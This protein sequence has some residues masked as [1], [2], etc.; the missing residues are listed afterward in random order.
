VTAIKVIE[1]Y[2]SGYQLTTPSFPTNL[3][4]N[5]VA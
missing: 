4:L 2:I 5:I 3:H 1:K